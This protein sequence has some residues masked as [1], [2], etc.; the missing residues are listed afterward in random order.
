V[1]AFYSTP[2]EFIAAKKSQAPNI[3]WPLKT[4]D[5]FPYADCPHC[6]WAGDSSTYCSPLQ[7]LRMPQSS[8]LTPCQWPC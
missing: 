8:L 5:F 7:E 3:S 1:N 6:F 4:D 2:A